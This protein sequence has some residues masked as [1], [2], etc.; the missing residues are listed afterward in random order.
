[1]NMKLTHF[2]KAQLA[3]RLVAALGVLVTACLWAEDPQL[4]FT[5]ISSQA[6]IVDI[7]NAGDGSNRLFLVKQSGL[8]YVHENG[9]T[10]AAPFL[11]MEDRVK[12]GGERGLLSMAFSPDYHSSGYFYVWYT[13]DDGETVLARF[14]VSNEPNLADPASHQVVLA[15]AQPAANHNGGRLQFGPDGMLYL[16]LGDGGGANDPAGNGQNRSTLLG[17]LIRI[18]VD[19]AHGTYAIPD[20]N[21]FVENAM[22]A[23][24]IW[25]LGL[26]NPWRI[27]FDQETGD[28]FI[29][30]V[31]QDVREEVNFQPASSTGGENY[32]W[33]IMEGTLC[34]GGNACDQ[35]G[36]ALPVVEYAHVDGNCS[37]TGGEVYRG[38]AYP[39]MYGM[40]LYGDYCSG[41]VWGL[42]KNG[43][44]WETIV[45]ADTSFQIPTFG[46]GEDGSLFMSSTDGIYLLSDGEV[47]PEQFVINAGLNDAWF[48]PD[49]AGQGFLISVFGDADV[50]FMAWFTF[51]VERP[52]E[53][54]TAILGDPGHRWLTAQGTFE[55]DTATMDVF[56]TVGGVFDSAE[57]AP[58]APVKI[59]TMTIKWSGCNAAVL[60]YDITSPALAGE[61]PI[62]RIVLD[63]VA[64]CQALQ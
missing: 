14:K 15:V 32:G 5:K 6:G 8:I 58:D 10:L 44:G 26:R 16:G 18:D 25:A 51:D 50:I 43:Q 36:L 34:S 20:D 49:T 31:G 3:A 45:L 9:A 41:R 59:G 22:V 33:S 27:S 56:Q 60:T 46:L 19:P 55:G 38:N 48:D 17:K 62:E 40:Y 24:E 21:P 64:L 47:V 35:P 7:V 12:G 53:D 39:N 37:I 42:R 4:E 52:A 57:P 61:I 63:N 30:D 29:A 23:D 2:L 13:D 54:V 28:V 11:D 1:M